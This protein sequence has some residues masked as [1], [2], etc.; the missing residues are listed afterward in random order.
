MLAREVDHIAREPKGNFVKREICERDA[1]SIDDIPVT[2]AA[3][4]R[5]GAVGNHGELPDLVRLSSDVFLIALAYGNRVK[6]PMHLTL[7]RDVFRL[8]GTV[9]PECEESGGSNTGVPCR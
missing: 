7:I 8:F 1:L 5:R 4:E 3:N 6:E 2:I 9:V